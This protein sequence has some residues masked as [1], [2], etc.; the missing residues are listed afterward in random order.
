M[1]INWG[2]AAQNNNPL[3]YFAMGQQ[4]G[5]DIRQRQTQNALATAINNP[6][7]QGALEEVTKLDPRMGMAL[8]QKLSDEQAK[9]LARNMEIMG[10]A[11]QWADTPEK[12]DQAIDYLAQS[13]VQ[14]VEQYKGKFSPQLRM[15]AIASSGE[16]KTYLDRTAPVNVGPGSHLVD[17]VT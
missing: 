10:Q 14:G 11:A 16:L 8:R 13:G 2:G 3:A 1:A 7:D 4:I 9:G 5:Q 15:S 17:P 12:W 6:Q